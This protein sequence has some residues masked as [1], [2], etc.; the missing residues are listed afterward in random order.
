MRN[1]NDNGAGTKQ[2]SDGNDSTIIAKAFMLSGITTIIAD[3]YTTNIVPLNVSVVFLNDGEGVATFTL[4]DGEQG[5]KILFINKEP[6]IT[7]R[8]T[9]ANLSGG[10]TLTFAAVG[11][12][13]ELTFAGD[14][15][16]ITGGNAYGVI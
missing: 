11:V 1:V 4:A 3:T 15:W 7:T 2:L 9:P 8:L 10:T 6:D 12:T 13:A 14:T 5:Q 16:Y